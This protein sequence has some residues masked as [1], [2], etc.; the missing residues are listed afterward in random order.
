MQGTKH[1]RSAA[2]SLSSLISGMIRRGRRSYAKKAA[3]K[4]WTRVIKYMRRLCRQRYYKKQRLDRDDVADI[5]D[6]NVVA[7]E[8]KEMVGKL[9]E[10]ISARAD[11][12]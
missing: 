12:S 5:T 6:F 11:R 9:N 2:L 3:K 1:S 7:A 4:N 10:E 8:E